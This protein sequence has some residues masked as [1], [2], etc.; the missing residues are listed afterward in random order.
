MAVSL[1]MSTTSD[2]KVSQMSTRTQGE[3]PG[4]KP[5]IPRFTGS[6]MCTKATGP[7]KT[8]ASEKRTRSRHV[9][10]VGRAAIDA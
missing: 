8:Q 7:R 5:A 1:M 4:A 10:L 3:I 2:Q 9:T 6:T